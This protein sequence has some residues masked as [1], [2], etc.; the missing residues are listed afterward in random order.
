LEFLKYAL[1]SVITFSSVLFAT[2]NDL[3]RVEASF[4]PKTILMDYNFKKR[5]HEGVMEFVVVYDVNDK[6]SAVKFKKMVDS[7][8]N[9]KLDEYHLHVTLVEYKNIQNID[10]SVNAFFFFSASSEEMKKA[11]KYAH[12]KKSLTFVYD[13]SDLNKGAMISVRV[14]KKIKPVI[15]MQVIR[16]EEISFRPIML[17][18]AEIF[19]QN[20]SRIEKSYYD[21]FKF[22]YV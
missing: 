11:I 12:A 8:H 20:Q 17:K 6:D 14:A 19:R 7:K 1:L 15:N 21:K 16:N 22:Y 10:Y 13:E 2:D 9:E 5:L 4:L 3:L 18:I